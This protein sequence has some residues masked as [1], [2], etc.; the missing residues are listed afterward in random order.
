M[1]FYSTATFFV[2]LI[3]AVSGA[4]KSIDSGECGNLDLNF[5]NRIWSLL[6]AD[7][8]LK[9]SDDCLSVT[10]LLVH[11]KSISSYPQAIPDQFKTKLENLLYT[12][13][14][15]NNNKVIEE[16]E[17]LRYLDTL[18]PNQGKELYNIYFHGKQESIIVQF[19]NLIR[20]TSEHIIN[21]MNADKN[22]CISLEEFKS[23]MCTSI[24]RIINLTYQIMDENND[25]SIVLEELKSLFIN[26]INWSTNILQ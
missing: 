15:K 9:K 21:E 3:C 26:I 2:L 20:H 11:A 16:N 19:M 18:I 14:D 4:K 25:K 8:T 23:G 7:T 5:V 24:D 1:K 6:S 22:D 12:L 13:F 17:M 10:Q